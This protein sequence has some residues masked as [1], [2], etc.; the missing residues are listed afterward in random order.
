MEDYEA[1]KQLRDQWRVVIEGDGGHCPCCDRWGKI[2]RR[3]LNS[4]MARSLIWLVQQPDRGDGWVHVPDNAP[5]WLLRSNQLG[6][7]HLW[8]LLEYVWYR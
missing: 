2:Y 4:S 7:L 8:G 6:T 1:L 5:A 3:G